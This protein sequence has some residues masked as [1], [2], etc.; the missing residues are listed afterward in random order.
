MRHETNEVRQKCSWKRQS[1][2]FWLGLIPSK[3][4]RAVGILKMPPLCVDRITL[5]ILSFPFL[6]TLKFFSSSERAHSFCRCVAIGAMKS[7]LN[8]KISRK[9]LLYKLS[10]PLRTYRTI[11]RKI[12]ISQVWWGGG[13]D[14]LDLLHKALQHSYDLLVFAIG[15]P[16]YA[17]LY[18][19][20]YP[21]LVTS[22]FPSFR[23]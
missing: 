3:R 20:L 2:L 17:P 18:T 13:V 4:K 11:F 19:L 22:D 7:F 16:L 10:N 14:W 8:T 1:Y 5:E 23:S 6:C 12:F 9:C 15:S 21:L